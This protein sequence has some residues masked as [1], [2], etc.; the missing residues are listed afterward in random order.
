VAIVA[1]Q[2]WA[3]IDDSLVSAPSFTAFVEGGGKS[4][5]AEL[6]WYIPW[7][8]TVYFVLRTRCLNSDDPYSP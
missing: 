8:L 1:G 2:R 6:M 5:V 3:I 7:Y 4:L